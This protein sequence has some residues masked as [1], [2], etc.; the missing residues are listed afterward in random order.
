ML[1]DG[2]LSGIVLGGFFFCA[3]KIEQGK[4]IVFHPRYHR[5]KENQ[6]CA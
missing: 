2:V 3:F 6:K 4:T 5:K 1:D